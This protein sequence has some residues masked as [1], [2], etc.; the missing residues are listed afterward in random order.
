MNKI[1]SAFAILCLYIYR[2]IQIAQFDNGYL[3]IYLFISKIIDM[4]VKCRPTK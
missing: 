3:F 4:L 1:V 2:K